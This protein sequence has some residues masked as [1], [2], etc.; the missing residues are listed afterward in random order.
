MQVEVFS[1]SG[2]SLGTFSISEET[3]VRE[4]KKDFFKKSEI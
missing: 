3:K 2:R 1:R 4:F